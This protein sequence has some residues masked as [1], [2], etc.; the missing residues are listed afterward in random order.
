VHVLVVDDEPD[1]RDLLSLILSGC[2]AVVRTSAS[3]E[4]ALSLLDDFVPDVLVSD[5]GM[6]GEDGYDLLRRV[7]ARPA[8]RGG[9]VPAVALT[10]YS[11]AEDRIRAFQAGFQIHVAKPV[12]PAELVMAINNLL[13]PL[14]GVRPGAEVE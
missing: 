7:R 13:A 9:R 6:P 5:I 4:E 8:D 10:A 12:E 1:T 3:A 2:D 11:R 14:G